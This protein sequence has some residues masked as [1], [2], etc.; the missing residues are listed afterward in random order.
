MKSKLILI[1]GLP[2]SG[3][4]TTASLVGEVLTEAGISCQVFQEGNLHHP[5]DFDGVAAI[6]HA[7]YHNLVAMYPMHV[8]AIT[9]TSLLDGDVYVV[10]Y[11]MLEEEYGMVF[12][13]DTKKLLVARD[14]YELSLEVNRELVK[15]NWERF[16]ASAKEQAAVFVFECNFIQNPVTIG[17]IKY[18]AETSLVE[19][20]IKDIETILLPL[21]PVLLYVDQSDIEASFTKAFQERPSR[22]QEGFVNY[23][24]TQGYGL[25][26][27]LKDVEGT[28]KVLDARNEVEQQIYEKLT[29]T[30]Y[31]VDNSSFQR[32]AMKEWIRNVLRI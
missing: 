32:D 25:K 15:R 13:P 26:R 12:S 3:K 10:H 16:V 31:K 9:H 2:G 30:K 5:A 17:M 18:G 24:T 23:Y 1:E 7:E 11:R 28:L 21:D 8:E 22:W 4:S 6:S 14:V 20:Y 19:S 29:L 27:N